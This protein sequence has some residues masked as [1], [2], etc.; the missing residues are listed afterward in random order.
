MCRAETRAQSIARKRH[1]LLQSCRG[2][3]RG[4]RTTQ[5]RSG[6]FCLLGC[7]RR[8]PP[9]GGSG[10]SRVGSACF[11]HRL[12]SVPVVVGGQDFR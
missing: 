10:I 3:L 12:P 8:L 5:L 7:P 6:A 4:A 2:S 1:N 11:L 9:A